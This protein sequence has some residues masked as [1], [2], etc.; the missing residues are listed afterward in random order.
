MYGS[1]RFSSNVGHQESNRCHTRGKSHPGE[2]IDMKS[3]NQWPAKEDSRRPKIKKI[4][5]IGT[6]DG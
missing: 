4:F 1:K 5:L 3:Q 2:I 6:F